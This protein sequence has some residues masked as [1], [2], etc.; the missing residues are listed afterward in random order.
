MNT[1]PSRLILYKT[2]KTLLRS[3]TILLAVTF[4]LTILAEEDVIYDD[5]EV[6]LPSANQE[7]DTDIFQTS[8]RGVIA[9][10]LAWK[11]RGIGIFS[12]GENTY[13]V[14]IVEDQTNEL[15]RKGELHRR[16]PNIPTRVYLAVGDTVILETKDYPTPTTQC[17]AYTFANFDKPYNFSETNGV[18]LLKNSNTLYKATLPGMLM[19]A[20]VD[21][22]KNMSNWSSVGAAVTINT[23]PSHKNTSLYIY[24][25]TPPGDWPKIAKSP[26]P[27]GQVYLFNG[28]TVMAFPAAVASLHADKNIDAMM[29]EHLIITTRYDQLNGFA[30]QIDNPMDTI[31]FSMYQASFNVCCAA[32]YSNGLIGI[33]FG[34]N[35]ITSHWGDWH[36]YGHQNQ[37]AWRWRGIREVSNNLF[38]LEACQML[39]GKKTENFTRCHSRFG[40]FITSDPEAV[41]RFLAMD[42]LPEN[43]TNPADQTLLML[44]QLYVSFPDWHAQLARDFRV[45]YARGDNA[46][47]FST[48]QQMMDWFAINSSRVVGRDL[49]GFFDK[50]K[51]PYSAES[52]QAIADLQLPQ[53]IKPSVQYSVDWTLS[54]QPTLEGVIPVP[55]LKH[56]LGLVAYGKEEGPTSLQMVENESYTKLTTLVVGSKRVPYSVVLRG[57][58]RRGEC[59]GEGPMHGI[60]TCAG[61]DHNVYWKLRYVPSDNLLPLPD[62]NY[63]GVLRL[64]IRAAYDENWGGTLTVPIKLAVSKNQ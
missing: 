63:E 58:L 17:F 13:Q 1:R 3:L 6:L 42:G 48:D 62:D 57:T 32:W 21:I 28:R 59:E 12:G 35:R 26:D 16:N 9:E 18:R 10:S 20:C 37:E 40:S 50:W 14:P 7:K 52:R 64:G 41:G 2:T 53:P 49:R 38:S 31:A 43:P 36:E 15:R 24:G 27:S 44:A 45:A 8:A 56:S 22:D 54:A 11:I 19:L 34:G 46:A 47:D 33:N 25:L 29:Q 39:T 61:Q 4:S 5:K 30:W 51:F 60:G 55:L 23:S